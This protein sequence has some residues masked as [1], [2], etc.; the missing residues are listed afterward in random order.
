MGKL[1]L[2]GCILLGLFSNVYSQTIPKNS[3]LI[4]KAWWSKMSAQYP[5][6]HGTQSRWIS[7]GDFNRDGLSDIV[8]QFAAVGTSRMFWQDSIIDSRKFKAV[9]LN[10]GNNNFELDSNQVFDF[11]GGDD[12]HIVL[13]VNGDGF[14]DVYQPTDNWHGSRSSMPKWYDSSENM[15]E[16]MFINKSNK[17]FEGSFFND[18]GGSTRHYQVI[19]IDQDKDDELAFLGLVDELPKSIPMRYPHEDSIQVFDYK[20]KFQRK[21]LQLFQRNSA[22][23]LFKSRLF[24]PMFSQ[25]DTLFGILKDPRNELRSSPLDMF[26]YITAKEKKAISKIAIPQGLSRKP[27]HNTGRQGFAQDLD[28]DGKNEYLFSFWKQSDETTYAVIFNENGQDISQRFFADSLN[29]KIGKIRSGISDV[30]DDI[31]HDGYM[32]ILPNHG[33]GFIYQ[34][35]FSYFLFNPTTK[36]YEVKKL[37]SHPI[38]FDSD[39]T[40]ADSLG[41]WP[42]YDYKTHTSFLQYFDKRKDQ[43]AMFTNIIAYKMDCDFIEK[44][45]LTYSTAGLCLQN[46]SL[47]VGLKKINVGSNYTFTFNSKTSIFDPKTNASNLKELGTFFITES[48]RDG[49]VLRSDTINITKKRIPV[50]PVISNSSPLTL[51][52][53]STVL[54]KSSSSLNQWYRN[55]NPIPNAFE[56]NY[57]ANVA[58][59]YKVKAMVDGCSSPLSN[60][61]SVVLIPV[62]GIPSITQEPNGSLTSSSNEWNQWYFNGLKIDNANQKSIIPTQGGNYTVKVESPC[63]TEVS[64]PMVVII[65]ATEEVILSQVNVFPNP[66]SHYFSVNFPTEFGRTVQVKVVD[67]S[68][69]IRMIKSIVVNGEQLDLSQ[70]NAGNYLLQILSN[71]NSN[72]KSIKISKLG[73]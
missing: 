14:L 48:S 11:K 17:S 35:Q 72:A 63:G 64:K 32:D 3:L 54:L 57:L 7:T 73:S 10:R 9:F 28:G 4:N 5:G 27:F 47:L 1:C 51:C 69:M 26:G 41:F 19:D 62:P 68:G 12:G 42:H 25:Q 30:F 6:F 58:G 67:H 8:L 49:C 65:T 45:R 55:G 61:A 36:K 70:L 43:D 52:A 38:L 39:Q 46:D 18:T 56:A 29:Y 53:G 13:D 22:D 44:P 60:P 20:G 59:E 23:S 16:F 66:I 15:G 50:A 34:N 2:V 21:T 37:H 71:D 33:I 31:N 24:V 40:R